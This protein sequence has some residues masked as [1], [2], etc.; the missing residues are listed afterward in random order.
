VDRGALLEIVKA[1]GVIRFDDPVQLSSG[2]WSRYFVDGKRALAGGADLRLA[3]EVMV[4]TVR[5]AGIEF[6]AAG[7]MT[8]GADHFSHGIAVVTGCQWFAIR[9]QPKGR[10]TNQRVEGAVLGPGVR[11]VVVD[12]AV[13]TGSSIHEAYEVVTAEGAEVVAATTLTDRADVGGRF[14]EERGV[15]YL[16]VFTYRDLGIPALGAED[17]A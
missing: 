15:P 1:R 4:D 2:D 6:D 7:G 9:K 16:P 8:M 17:A 12:D 3:C 13:T 14:F 10:G 5:G 11:V